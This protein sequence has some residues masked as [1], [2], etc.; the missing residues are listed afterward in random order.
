MRYL[1]AQGMATAA[2]F[3]LSTNPAVRLY[4]A[5]GY[6]TAYTYWWYA[7]AV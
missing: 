1:R 2:L 6:R 5:V 4:E 3:A 7:K